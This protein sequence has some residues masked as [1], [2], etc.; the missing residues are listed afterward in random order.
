MSK[1]TS[2]IFLMA[3]CSISANFCSLILN[4]FLRLLLIGS[5]KLRLRL[6]IRHSMYHMINL[7][8]K[9]RLGL[10]RMIDRL[11][12]MIDWLWLLINRLRLIIDR[13]RQG[14]R[15][16]LRLIINRL[17]QGLRLLINRLRGL[18]LLS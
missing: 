9:M 10:R 7:R 14:L 16:G 3:A 1:V 15:Q 6:N 11:R 8:L 5:Y 18:D 12:L 2:I 13:L 17:R 4:F